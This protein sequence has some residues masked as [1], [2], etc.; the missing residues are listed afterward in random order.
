[1]T[2][3]L[4]PV[5]D[6]RVPRYPAAAL[7]QGEPK[8][9]GPMISNRGSAAPLRSAALGRVVGLA[10]WTLAAVAPLTALATPG[11]V[12]PGP[13]EAAPLAGQDGPAKTQAAPVELN[14]LT[15]AEIEGLV[16]E[17]KQ[18]RQRAMA[19]KGEMAMYTAVLTEQE[20][21]SILNAFLKKNGFEPKCVNVAPGGET[22]EVDAWDAARGVGIAFLPG[23]PQFGDNQEK[24]GARPDK[25][26][27]E[28]ALLRARGEARVLVLDGTDYEYDPEGYMAGTL[29]SKKAA[30]QRLLAAVEGFIRE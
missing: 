7:P 14:R 13:S 4:R 5:S 21:R 22:I 12:A 19:V 17:F 11:G 20:A 10:A 6:Y 29:P 1:M 25:A 9:P 16:G 26:I 28:L 8:L 15:D 27:E 18:G 23:K 3:E 24:V 2:F 30:I